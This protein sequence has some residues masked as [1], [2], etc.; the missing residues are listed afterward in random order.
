MKNYTHLHWFEKE[1]GEF[2]KKKEKIK[3]FR[4]VY[5]HIQYKKE[6]ICKKKEVG[7]KSVCLQVEF[8]KFKREIH[9]QSKKKK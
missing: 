1:R 5:L 7:F 9:R 4:I 8:N 2:R 3:M 6:N